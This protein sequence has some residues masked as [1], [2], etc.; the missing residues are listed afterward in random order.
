MIKDWRNRWQYDFPFFFVQ[1]A[2]Y[3][4]TEEIN[5]HQSQFL[6]DSQRKSLKLSNTGMVV[7]LD[8]ETL[9]IFIQQINKRLETD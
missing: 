3:K 6:R 5:N 9:A 4:Y 1:I 7:T 8:I 2:P